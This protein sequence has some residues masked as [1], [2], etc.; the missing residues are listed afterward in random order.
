M[1]FQLSR[2][3]GTVLGSDT[4]T[5]AAQEARQ[6]NDIYGAV[7]AGG[8]VTTDAVLTVTSDIPVF[9]YV[10]VID[11]QTGDSVIQ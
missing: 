3:D 8:L 6:V 9:S 4:Q 10:T 5:W 1:T 2:T 11:N 7:G